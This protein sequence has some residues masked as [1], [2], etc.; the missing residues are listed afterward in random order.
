MASRNINISWISNI[1]QSLIKTELEGLYGS[2]VLQDMGEIIELYDIYENG[3]D[4]DTE[5]NGD[6]V[7]AD[8]KYRI[9]RALLDKEV[10]FLFSLPPDFYVD[11]D[12]DEDKDK[13]K[14][15]ASIY[16]DL[17]DAVLA[18]NNFQLSL[19]KAAKDCFIGKRVDRKS[20]V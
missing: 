10:R 14:E 13:A 7:P 12:I 2:K 17:V 18:K 20:V 16:K 9:A 8:L 3:S 4:F 11:V 15:D 1:P 6:Y 19:I 5:T